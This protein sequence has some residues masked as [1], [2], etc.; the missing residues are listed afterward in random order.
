MVKMDWKI[1]K[2][3]SRVARHR[4]SMADKGMRPIQLWV[5]DSRNPQVALEALRQCESVKA[6]DAADPEVF[7]L[8][9][10]ALMDMDS[11]WKG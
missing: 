9:N 6:A 7:D 11:E 3:K 2:P 5:A 4:R 1:D 8:L 10:D